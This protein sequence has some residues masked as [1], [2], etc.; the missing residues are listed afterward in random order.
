MYLFKSGIILKDRVFIPDYDNYAD[1]FKELNIDGNPENTK[2]IFVRVELI[3]Q[4]NNVFSDI[5]TWRFNVNQ[6]IVP[7]WFVK[8]YEKERMITAVKEWAKSRIYIGVDGLELST[9]A[10]YYLKD[11]NDIILTGNVNIAMLKS[12]TV[13]LMCD[14]TIVEKMCDSSTVGVMWDS[15]NIREMCDS[16]TV[17]E[18]WDS[19]NIREMNDS[20][21]V[22]KMW[23][24]STVGVMRQRSIV[25][26]ML[27]GSTVR[28][29]RD[30][31]TVRL[32][33]DNSTVET[34]WESSIVGVMSGSS[35]IREMWGSSTVREMRD[36]SIV[37]IQNNLFSKGIKQDSIILCD[38]AV[39]KD[40]RTKTIYHS[41][42]WKLVLIENSEIR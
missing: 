4:D 1:M 41:G 12:S 23:D 21:I 30:S 5:A 8:D 35:N 28:D 17:R 33:C 20:S 40:S 22:E 2:P 29:M 32:M 18:M 34:M 7:D 3:P 37:S 31:S 15:S 36:S 25:E 19:S 24:S 27:Q 26:K 11:C 14:S 10:N 9:G 16:S 42:D 13:R 39:I 6:D 38:N